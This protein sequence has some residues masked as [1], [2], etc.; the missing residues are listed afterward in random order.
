MIRVW[1]LFFFRLAAVA[2]FFLITVNAF[3]DNLHCTERALE[4]IHRRLLSLQILIY[5]EEMTDLIK[6]ML[7]QL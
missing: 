4:F 6:D 1:P 7:R 3:F 5:A 2:I